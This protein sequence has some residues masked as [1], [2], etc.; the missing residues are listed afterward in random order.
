MWSAG[1]RNRSHA[2]PS[3]LCLVPSDRCPLRSIL[4][5]D[6]QKD[7]F[8]R[9]LREGKSSAHD[10]R[11]GLPGASCM[12]AIDAKCFW[13]CRLVHSPSTIWILSKHAAWMAYLSLPMLYTVSSPWWIRR[14]F[15]ACIW[16]MPKDIPAVYLTFDDGPHPVATPFVLDA[17]RAYGMKAT[18]FCIGQNVLAYP[19]LY[20][21]ILDEGHSVGNHTHRHLSGWNTSDADYLDDIRAAGRHITSDLFRPPYGRITFSQLRKLGSGSAPMRT[22]M[23]SVLSGDFDARISPEKCLRNVMDH[24]KAGSIVTFHESEKSMPRMIKVLCYV[25]DE[26][27]RQGWEGKKM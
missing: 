9:V 12:Q 1:S 21:R 5:C 23:W 14:L 7:Q 17:L 8:E 19:D 25:L 26:M 16:E 24:M 18:F 22:V 13:H 10:R 4:S 2:G 11:V 3:G 27:K 15:P 20:Q 6:T